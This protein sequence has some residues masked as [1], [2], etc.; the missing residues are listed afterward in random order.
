MTHTAVRLAV[1]LSSEWIHAQSSNMS[2]K[3]PA[4]FR[5]SPTPAAQ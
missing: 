5:R 3:G 1:P 4:G 2:A